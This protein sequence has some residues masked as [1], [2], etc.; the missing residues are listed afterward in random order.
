MLLPDELK[1]LREV[2]AFLRA[3]PSS[4]VRRRRRVF[5]AALFEHADELLFAA[6]ALAT[7]GGT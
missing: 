1:R 4:A 3:A 5:Q 6:E 7:G 2:Q